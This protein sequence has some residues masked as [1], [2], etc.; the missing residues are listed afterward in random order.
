MHQ[1]RITILHATIF[2]AGCLIAADTSAA[3]NLEAGAQLQQFDY[4]EYDIQG[5][6]LLREHGTMPVLSLDI[7]YPAHAV[8]SRLSLRYAKSTVKYDGRTQ[9]GQ[10]LTTD[11]DE[12]ISSIEINFQPKP[13]TSGS[14]I[15]GPHLGFGFREWR[16]EIQATTTTTSLKEIYRWSYH[17]IGISAAWRPNDSF[18]LG[19]SAE[20]FSA[21][22]PH[23]EVHVPGYDSTILHLNQEPG[24]RLKFPITL[25]TKGD[26]KWYITPYWNTWNMGRSDTKPLRINGTASGLLITEP[27]SKT[28]VWG[29]SV[30]TNL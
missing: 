22:N 8:T 16:R 28:Q 18:L 11:T 9:G 14:F 4:Q 25:N 29:I 7:S 26:R 24:Y 12:H 27:E 17:I 13:S 1:I 20:A 23:I 30:S 21:V 3:L 6:R 5:D 10:P 2:L 15:A 19:I